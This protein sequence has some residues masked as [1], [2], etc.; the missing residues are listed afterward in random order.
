MKIVFVTNDYDAKVSIPKKAQLQALN[1]TDAEVHIVDFN[2][3][4]Q[5]L[6]ISTAPCVFLLFDE[7]QGNFPI[8]NLQAIREAV[9]ALAL[10]ATVE[11]TAD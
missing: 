4:R 6:P 10:P 1:I 2:Q 7:L 9:Q 5:A 11:E 8:E 3:V